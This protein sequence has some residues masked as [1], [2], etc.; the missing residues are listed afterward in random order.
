[1][2]DFRECIEN[3]RIAGAGTTREQLD[4]FDRQLAEDMRG[5]RYVAPPEP[6]DAPMKARGQ[7]IPEPLYENLGPVIDELHKTWALIGV[8]E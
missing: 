6:S 3:L 2:S 7:R 4:R 5:P 1:V 8:D